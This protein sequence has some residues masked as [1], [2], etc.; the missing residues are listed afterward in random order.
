MSIGGSGITI[1]DKN[2]LLLA[3]AVQLLKLSP[4]FDRIPY[5]WLSVDVPVMS[6]S[7]NKFHSPCTDLDSPEL[8]R[9][10]EYFQYILAPVNLAS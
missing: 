4:N 2:W 10:E 5:A 9:D 7:T 8:D 6:T 1:V 3:P